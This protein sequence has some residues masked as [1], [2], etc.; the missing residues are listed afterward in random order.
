MKKTI[1]TLFLIVS[2]IITACNHHEKK[3]IVAKTNKKPLTSH[4]ADTNQILLSKACLHAFSDQSK[5]DTFKLVMKGKSINTGKIKFEI[6]SFNN[7]KIYSED[8]NAYDLLGDLDNL[9]VKQNEDTIRTRFNNFFQPENF[10]APALDRKLDLLDTDYVDLKT[11]KDISSDPTAIGFTYSVGYEG[12]SEIA[13][14]KRQKMTVV[15][16]ASD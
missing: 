1:S 13:Y 15:C 8:F 7:Q 4:E 5:L 3:L 12:F 14:S 16:A 9:S 2:I 11:Q 6:I 10:S